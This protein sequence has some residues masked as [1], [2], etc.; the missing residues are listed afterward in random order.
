MQKEMQEKLDEIVISDTCCLIS[1][2]KINKLELLKNLYNNVYITPDVLL[3][4]ERGGSKI[5]SFIK[6]KEVENKEEIKKLINIGL[7]LGEA[8]SFALYNECKN[9]LLL[10][11][12]TD[13]RNYAIE[14]DLNYTTTLDVLIKAREEGYITSN[15]E[16]HNALDN[17]V[18][19][20]RWMSIEVIEEIKEN[21]K[22]DE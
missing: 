22:I 1:F 4:Y 18:I 14:N 17:L 7:H 15:I 19:K 5:P 13:A 2:E 6:I 8:S 3:E 11:D 10:T 12:D 20:K 16:L 9:A 21:Y